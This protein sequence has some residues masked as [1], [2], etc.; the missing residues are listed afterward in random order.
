MDSTPMKE[1]LD[2]RRE[3]ERY[4]AINTPMSFKISKIA[5]TKLMKKGL[6]LTSNPS[7]IARTLMDVGAKQLGFDLDKIN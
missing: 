3:R 2:Q 6:S 5:A 7:E 4:L 1:S